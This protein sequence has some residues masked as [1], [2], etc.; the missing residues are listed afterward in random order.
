L[1]AQPPYRSDPSPTDVLLFT[2]FKV[3][4]KGCGFTSVEE[5][6]ENTLEQVTQSF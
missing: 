4:L 5:I 1:V 2:K 3:S 6:Q